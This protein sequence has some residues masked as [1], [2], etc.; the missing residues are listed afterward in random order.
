MLSLKGE[1]MKNKY[2]N[3]LM[4]ILTS[5]AVMFGIKYL[6][7]YEVSHVYWSQTRFYMLMV[8]GAA[9]A[10]VM[11]L[12]MQNMYQ[13]KKAN[14]AII[15]I[16]ALVFS[17]FLYLTRT[18]NTIADQRWME[19][20][21]PHHSI[22]ILTSK[23]AN[24]KDIRVQELANGII[25]AQEKEIK[26]MQ[27]LLDDIEKNGIVTNEQERIERE[28]PDFSEG[29]NILQRIQTTFLRRK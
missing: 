28:V 23:R 5:M 27:W 3:F 1:D 18:Q 15:A 11:L 24:I 29:Q 16:S 22:A 4:M 25:K 17:T 2:T 10:V 9:M 7:T 8:M 26:E 21:I 13:N 14:Y 20:M 6:T 12:F 19:A